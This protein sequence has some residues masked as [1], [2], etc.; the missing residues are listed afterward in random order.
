MRPLSIFLLFFS[1]SL[2]LAAC[3][4]MAPPSAPSE[5]EL[6]SPR[7]GKWS[8]A[9]TGGC[10]GRESEPL[11]ITRLDETEIVFDDFHLLL[12]EDDEYVGSAIFIASMPVDGREIPYEIAYVLKGTDAGSFVGTERVTEGGGQSLGCPI[13]LHYSGD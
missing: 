12:N 8:L 9:Y 13:E 5:R 2:L 1:L 11:L 10:T 7:V 6:D 4:T 3:G